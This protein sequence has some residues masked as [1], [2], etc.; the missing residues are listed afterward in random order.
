MSFFPQYADLRM[1]KMKIKRRAPT[2]LIPVCSPLL[3]GC[4]EAPLTPLPTAVCAD[5]VLT[6]GAQEVSG[7]KAQSAW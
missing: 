3:A 7:G 2:G 1:L 4:A 6:L 5:R